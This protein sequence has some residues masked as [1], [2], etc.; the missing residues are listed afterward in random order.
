MVNGNKQCAY[1][2]TLA[3]FIAASF[4]GFIRRNLLRLRGAAGFPAALFAGLDAA[5]LKRD[6]ADERQNNWSDGVM[7]YKEEFSSWT[8][9]AFHPSRSCGMQ[10]NDVCRGHRGSE[11][12]L[13]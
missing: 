13:P 5:A 3:S 11:E 9:R 12:W 7:G 10:L 8:R 2:Q 6:A 4:R 1:N